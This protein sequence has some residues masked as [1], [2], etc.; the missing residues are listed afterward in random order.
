MSDREKQIQTLID[1]GDDP[2]DAERIVQIAA[3]S[4]LLPQNASVASII[5]DSDIE[6]ARADWYASDEVPVRFKRLL[7]AKVKA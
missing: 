7:D 1:L 4:P 2:A 6:D 5:T 3:E